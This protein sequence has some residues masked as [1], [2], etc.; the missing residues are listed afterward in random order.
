MGL[1]LLRAALTVVVLVLF[2]S[3]C[4]TAGRTLQ[5]W[6]KRGLDRP[7]SKALVSDYSGGLPTTTSLLLETF[8]EATPLDTFRDVVSMVRSEYVDKVEDET[9]LA[10]GAVRAMLYSL[11]DPATR[12]WTREQY[13]MLRKQ[14]EGEFTGIGAHV[15][16]RKI[17]RDDIEQRR[18][19]VVA[20]VPGGPAAKAGIQAGDYITEIDGK[21]IIA[22][23]PRLDL[24]RLALRS[25]PDA[26][27]RR[28]MKEA[29]KKL[30]DGVSW[31]RALEALLSPKPKALKLTVER[32]GAAE[33]ITVEL[34][35]ATTR[36]KPAEFRQLAGGIGHLRVRLFNRQTPELVRGALSD[37]SRLKGLVVD[38]RDNAVIA[39]VDGPGSP[40]RALSETLSAL[41]VKGPVAAI[42]R[43]TT[44]RAVSCRDAGV[45]PLPTAVVVNKGTSGLAEVAAAALKNQVGAS[46]VGAGTG[47][48]IYYVRLVPLSTGA[49]TVT[50]GKW[51]VN[52]TTP[53]TQAGV[54]P[55]VKVSASAGSGGSDPAVERARTLLLQKG[56]RA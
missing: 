18:V 52:G 33:P 40:L 43:D 44:K 55:D 21:W 4:F 36:V 3:A 37:R 1:R 8:K 46:I 15:A 22:Y 38:L 27:Y 20:A 14:L 23:D 24:N 25:M 31:P 39:D 53:L 32:P 12:Y 42:A 48:N 17:K 2:T 51:V 47:G 13:E 30:T 54:T 50:S 35:P 6:T 45:K 26:E 34:E 29:T 11:D 16:V 10:A 9:K 41:G 7:P 49:M 19:V 28:K 5:L 56:G